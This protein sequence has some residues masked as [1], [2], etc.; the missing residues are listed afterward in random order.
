[1]KRIIVLLIA[2]AL[3]FTLIGCN[4]VIVDDFDGQVNTG[5]DLPRLGDQDSISNN[6]NV[7]GGIP[8]PPAFPG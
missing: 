8:V 7:V 6:N 2:C 4:N 3:L 5:I 1:M